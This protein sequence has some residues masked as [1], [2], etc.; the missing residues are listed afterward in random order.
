MANPEHLN[1]LNNGVEAWNNWRQANPNIRPNLRKANLHGLDLN[2]A[3]FND[4]TLRRADLSQSNLSQASFRRADLRRANLTE[5]II[6]KADLTSAILIETNLEKAELYDCLVYGIS[7]WNT[8][9]KGTRQKNLIISKKSEPLLIVDSLEVAQFIYLLI[10]NEKIREVIN[11]IGQKTVLILGR[12]SPFERKEVLDSIGDKL[13]ELGFV[14]IIFDFEGSNN[15]DFTETI[16]I[17]A[18]LSLFVIADIT[19]PKSSPLELQASIPEYKIPFVT[20]L[21]NGE[22][23]FSM[24]K[25]LTMFDWVLKA[26]ITYSTRQELIDGLE[27]VVIKPAIQKHK[28]LIARKTEE[29]KIRSI[30][31]IMQDIKSKSESI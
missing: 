31:E 2:N 9:L 17:L 27:L 24:F 10:D 22:E 19:N 15:R 11:T 18:G 8:Q 23:P 21:K 14:P 12:F 5:S 4:S 16:K 30:E 25:D 28:E 1:I 6:H 13:R 7:A 3:N 29:L 26:V 20:I